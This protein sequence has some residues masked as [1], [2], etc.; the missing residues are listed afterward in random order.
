MK[1]RDNNEIEKGDTY[2]HK[3]GNHVGHKNV[4]RVIRKQIKSGNNKRIGDE[5]KR[6]KKG[7]ILT[8]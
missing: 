4:G 3:K 6:W 1:E 7:K 2:N 5:E 8:G